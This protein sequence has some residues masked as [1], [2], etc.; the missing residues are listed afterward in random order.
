MLIQNGSLR[1]N[2]YAPKYLSFGAM[3]KSQFDGID[4]AAVEKYKAP[5]EKFNSNQHFQ[6]WADVQIQSILNKNYPG[7]HT[8]TAAQ[9]KGIIKQWSDIL[10]D[11]K[12]SSAAKLLILKG[13]TKDLKPNNDRLPPDFNRD[14]FCA[15][16]QKLQKAFQSDPDFQFDFSKIYTQEM[17][18][19]SLKN[20]P[21][22]QKETAWIIIPSQIHDKENFEKNVD[23]L[24]TFS[25]DRW[26]TKN[27]LAEPYLRTDDFHI[28]LKNDK[29]ELVLRL[30][31]N[32]ILEIQGGLNN[33]TVPQEYINKLDYHIKKYNLKSCSQIQ[34]EIDEAKQRG[35]LLEEIKYHLKDVIK[36]NDIESIFNYFNFAYEKNSDGL[37]TL[38][39]GY[40]QPQKGISWKDIGINENNLLEHIKQINGY[41]DFSHSD[42]TN[43]GAVKKINGPLNLSYSKLIDLGKLEYVKNINLT[44]SKIKTLGNLK[45]IGEN[46][47]FSHSELTDLG[48]LN[49]IGKNADFSNSKITSLGNLEYI[50]GS[51]DF[52]DSNVSDS[53]FLRLIG[54]NADFT[55][56]KIQYLKCLQKIGGNAIFNNSKIKNLGNLEFIGG[57]ADFYNSDIDSL[58]RL[59]EIQGSAYFGQTPLTSL[60]LLERIGENIRFTATNIRNLGNLKYI[61]KNAVF[62]N[63]KVSNLNYLQEI[64]GDADFSDSDI[65]R[66]DGLRFIGGNATFD[67]N[68]VPKNSQIHIEGNVIKKTVFP[69]NNARRNQKSS[70]FAQMLKYFTT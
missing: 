35:I 42:A 64:D 52:K 36:N 58:G 70:S 51:A 53:G 24:K 33:G 67:E 23:L 47:N 18:K 10:N 50:G 62:S 48:N 22:S 59:K 31:N 55:N 69:I 44:N 39:S 40:Y 6:A 5:I 7:R 37:L 68:N 2:F 60:D 54:E 27:K 66:F 43:L 20:L 11:E 49:Y 65:N 26:C 15:A 13:I 8:F 41:C 4:Y 46:A 29:P 28:L 32:T 1:N 56:S 45:C 38:N 12:Y 61:G 14:A 3:K 19:F 17:R 57:Y 30:K 25:D 21:A 63:S 34:A 9:R 16:M